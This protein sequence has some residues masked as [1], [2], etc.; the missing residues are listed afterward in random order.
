MIGLSK[1]GQ[2]GA[3]LSYAQKL[4]LIELESIKKDRSSDSIDGCFFRMTL[5]SLEAAVGRTTDPLVVG[6]FRE[7]VGD[8]GH[9]R[10][11]EEDI[12]QHFSNPGHAI[13]RKSFNKL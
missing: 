8:L 13:D 9:E 1:I 3:A 2:V 10:I 7:I 11:L 5:D 12:I 6:K 4:K